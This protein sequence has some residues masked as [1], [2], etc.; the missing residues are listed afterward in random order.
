[1]SMKRTPANYTTERA[2]LIAIDQAVNGWGWMWRPTTPPDTGVDGTIEVAEVSTATGKQLAV[3]AKSG[4]SYFRN[5]TETTFEFLAR[6]EDVDYW[7]RYALPVLLM[8]Y[9]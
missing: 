1:M 4:R 6:S 3:Q 5:E 7:K 2:G 8:V 9:D